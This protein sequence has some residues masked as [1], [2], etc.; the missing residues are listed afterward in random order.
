VSGWLE[1]QSDTRVQHIVFFGFTGDTRLQRHL[2]ELMVVTVHITVLCQGRQL[3][4]VPRV[5]FHNIPPYFLDM[6]LCL[7]CLFFCLFLFEANLL[8]GYFLDMELQ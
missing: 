3:P 4:L 7:W 1:S 5:R 8:M 2:P 6:F